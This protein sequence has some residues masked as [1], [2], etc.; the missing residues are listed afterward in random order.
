VKFMKEE[1]TCEIC[2][3]R[4]AFAIIE[5]EGAKL[6]VCGSCAYGKKI[7]YN[8]DDAGEP[9][10]RR[11]RAAPKNLQETEEIIEGYGKIIKNARENLGLT[12]TVVAE[13]ISEREGYLEKIEREELTPTFEIAK[14]LEKELGITLVEK[15]QASV[16]ASAQTSKKFSEPTLADMLEEEK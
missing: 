3:R 1:E 2:G 14:K 11:E 9:T 6:K 16:A 13:R 15:V 10:G 5:V 8:L 7:L 12:R 4:G